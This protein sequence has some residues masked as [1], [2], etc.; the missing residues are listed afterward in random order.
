M[1]I[2]VQPSAGM[3]DFFNRFAAL[4]PEQ[5]QDFGYLAQLFAECGMEVVGPP[6]HAGDDTP[7]P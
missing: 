7:A 1:L 3:E 6:L 2:L 5:L 4:S